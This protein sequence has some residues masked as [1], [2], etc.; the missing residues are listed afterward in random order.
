MTRL[1]PHLFVIFGATGDLT[2]RKLF[3]AI[4]RMMS[5][6][7]V[8]AEVIGVATS[9]WDDEQFRAMDANADQLLEENEV[10]TSP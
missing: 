9:E 5:D 1:E 10:K 2:R 3:P 4:Y 7:A 6:D 8:H